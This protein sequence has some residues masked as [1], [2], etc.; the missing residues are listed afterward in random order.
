MVSRVWL[1]RAAKVVAWVLAALLFLAAAEHQAFAYLASE[2]RYRLDRNTGQTD[3]SPSPQQVLDRMAFGSSDSLTL[4]VTSDIMRCRRTDMPMDLL[5][6]I[7][8]QLGWRGTYVPYRHA[9]EGMIALARQWPDAPILAVGDLEQGRGTPG[10]FA[11]CFAPVW[12]DLHDRTLPAPG[13]HEYITPGAFAYYDFWGQQAGPDRRGYYA[14]TWRNWLILSLNSE[15]DA[16]PGSPQAR[17]VKQQLDQFPQACVMAVFHRPAY[18]IRHRRFGKNALALFQQI[19]TAG[20]SLVLNGH[21]HFFE[22]SKPINAQ[23][24]VDG[25]HGAIRFTAGPGGAILEPKVVDD[26]PEHV[27]TA[28]IGV[29]GLLRIVLHQT[30]FDWAFHLAPDATVKDHGTAPCR[31]RGTRT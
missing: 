23:G 7:S 6:A 14:V 15:I 26:L 24:L 22:R 1:V 16:R 11:D 5:P 29:P 2:G 4:L 30:T 28:L 31:P 20:G 25:A 10:E 8:N 13:N 27:A 18:S 9:P 21:N 3:P 19:Q 12:D 17:W